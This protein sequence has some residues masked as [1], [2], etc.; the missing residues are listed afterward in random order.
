MDGGERLE[1]GVKWAPGPVQS[2]MIEPED[3]LSGKHNRLIKLNVLL[4]TRK[5]GKFWRGGVLSGA[6]RCA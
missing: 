6:G 2:G 3:R 4:R 5:E 1:S